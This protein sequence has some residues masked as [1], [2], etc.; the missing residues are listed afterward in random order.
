M[1]SFKCEKCGKDIIDTPKGYI[2]GCEHYPIEK[3][4]YKLC[5]MSQNGELKKELKMT[6][7][8]PQ[9]YTHDFEPYEFN[10]DGSINRGK[11]YSGITGKRKP[12]TRR[13]R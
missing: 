5:E 7:K 11:G 2:T 4:L 1:S 10:A 8:L 6:D 3:D 12:K 9:T 13:K